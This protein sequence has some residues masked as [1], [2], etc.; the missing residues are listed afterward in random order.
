MV[1]RDPTGRGKARF[2]RGPRTSSGA[3]FISS[4]R[5]DDQTN[6]LR[7][8][9]ANGKSVHYVGLRTRHVPCITA[10]LT[11]SEETHSSGFFP[12]AAL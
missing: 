9:G 12:Q 8:L 6:R 7:D 3:I 2:G 10:T 11:P 5:E 1:H 4:L